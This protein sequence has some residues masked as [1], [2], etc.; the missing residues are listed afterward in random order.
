MDAQGYPCTQTNFD[1]LIRYSKL[2]AWAKFPDFQ[3]RIRDLILKRQGRRDHHR[4]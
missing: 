1:T 3:T 2:D 4:L